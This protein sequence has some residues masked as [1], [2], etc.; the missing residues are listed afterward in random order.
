MCR[1]V[2]SSTASGAPGAANRRPGPRA[3][4]G[5][6][7]EQRA[8]VGDQVELGVIDAPVDDG[9][10]GQQPVPGQERVLKLA[11]VAARVGDPLLQLGV[12]AAR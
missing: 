3:R 1:T 8:V 4:S 5:V 6:R 9:E 2:R 12:Q 7:V 10:Q 11:L